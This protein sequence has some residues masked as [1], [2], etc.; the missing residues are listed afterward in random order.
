M[1]QYWL[2]SSG[3]NPRVPGNFAQQ[4]HTTTNNQDGFIPLVSY[5]NMEVYFRN[6]NYQSRPPAQQYNFRMSPRRR[7]A[8][9]FRSFN[10]SSV[11]WPGTTSSHCPYRRRPLRDYDSSRAPHSHNHV[12]NEPLQ[13]NNSITYNVK[14]KRLPFFEVIA[15]LLQIDTIDKNGCFQSHFSFH[16]KPHIAKHFQNQDTANKYQVQLRIG[17]LDGPSEQVDYYP[18]T[19]QILV[20]NKFCVLPGFETVPRG[21]ARPVGITHLCNLSNNFTNHI[22]IRNTSEKLKLFIYVVKK[23]TSEDLVK[24]LEAR[25][26]TNPKDTAS[27]IK[28]KLQGG[29]SGDEIAS[30]TLHCSLLCP[31]GKVRM[32]LPCRASTCS[33]FQ[34]FDAV[35]YL[36]LNE[37]K[38]KWLCPVCS[39]AASYDDLQIDG[40]KTPVEIA[41]SLYLKEDIGTVTL[42][43]SRYF[44]AVLKE[45]VS[46]DKIVLQADGSWKPFIPTNSV[47]VVESVQVNQTV[48]LDSD[49][50]TSNIDCI[51]I[52]TQDNVCQQK[53]LN[54]STVEKDI[55]SVE[56]ITLSDDEALDSTPQASNNLTCSTPQKCTIQT[57][58]SSST[59]S[60]EYSTIEASQP[61]NFSTHVFPLFKTSNI[62]RGSKQGKRCKRKC[63]GNKVNKTNS[64]RNSSMDNCENS[65]MNNSGNSSRVSN[66][67]IS[68]NN[69]T[70][71]SN[72]FTEEDLSD[73]PSEDNDADVSFIPYKDFDHC[74]TPRTRGTTRQNI[75]T[76]TR[77][78]KRMSNKRKKKLKRNLLKM[79]GRKVSRRIFCKKLHK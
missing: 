37:L 65:S 31:L 54:T 63:K 59:P 34:C 50:D 19:L 23:L 68:E 1:S 8:D 20:N 17:K 7:A 53:E 46:S 10:Y 15:T 2:P 38:A 43:N 39:K 76:K 32:K 66:M 78:K 60:L 27:A 36:Q 18:N 71:N 77:K 22:T 75:L 11:Q 55:S 3:R 29:Q 73:C 41:A 52:D 48:N 16:L 13:P 40:S 57:R 33:H 12:V 58:S 56:T 79:A 30:T 70:N 74:G 67:K 4:Y 51:E 14:L 9:N 35:I 64:S 5:T 62:T 25:K 28:E 6:Q 72:E 44:K 61:M 45:N 26:P 21:P 42:S 69:P 47:S 49:G 24:K